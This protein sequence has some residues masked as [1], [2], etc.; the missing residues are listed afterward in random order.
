MN[1]FILTANAGAIV[2]AL[3]ACHQEN[4]K[5]TQLPSSEAAAV[6]ATVAVESAKVTREQLS[7][8]VIATGTTE[9]A[10]EANLGPQMT[11]RIARILVKEGDH[12]KV[13]AAL[14][15]LD[16]VEASLRLQQVTANAAS[17]RSQ[18]DLAKSEY[19]R[20]AP[21]AE[22]GTVTPQQLERLASQRDALKAGAD[23]ATVAEADAKRNMTNTAVRAPFPGIVSKVQMDVGEIA[24]MMPPSVILRLVDLSS[25]D[26]RVRVHERELARVV[27]GDA[28]DARFP[29][30]GQTAKGIVTFISPE[31]DPRTRNAEVVTRI[32]N[33][34]GVLRAGMFAEIEIKPKGAQDAL[35]IPSTAVAG[36]GD[37]RFIFAINGSTVERRKVRIAAIDS[38]RVEILEGLN[39]GDAIVA[40]GLGRL[41]DGAPISLAGAAPAAPTANA[42]EPADTTQK[43]QATGATP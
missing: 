1:R 28:V 38:N 16:T 40:S 18:Y 5:L 32:P 14:A 39:E 13:G 37:N 6:V 22:R 11:A 17:T 12:V 35:V 19:E 42:A 33:A 20:L 25:V 36:T 4:E 9:P 15:Q 3:T 24:T 31:I 10:R 43:A 8:A 34:D 23:A 27:L 26:V 29:S 41:S 2:L 30:S 21:L 7:R